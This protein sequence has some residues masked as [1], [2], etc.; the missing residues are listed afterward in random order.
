MPQMI[1]VQLD[2]ELQ[3]YLTLLGRVKASQGLQVGVRVGHREGATIG[4]GNAMSIFVHM[5]SG[6]CQAPSTII[7]LVSIGY[8]ERL[9]SQSGTKGGDFSGGVFVLGGITVRICKRMYVED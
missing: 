2:G 9:G 4:W 8:S 7:W 6:T 5:T 1:C 3:R